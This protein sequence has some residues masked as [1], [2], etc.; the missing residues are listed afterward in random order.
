M[1]EAANERA[2][3]LKTAV[4]ELNALTFIAKRQL[5]LENA[6]DGNGV[7][8]AEWSAVHRHALKASL[9]FYSYCQQCVNAGADVPVFLEIADLAKLEKQFKDVDIGALTKQ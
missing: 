6:P 2:K 5:D 3:K 1:D 8:A 4:V 9:A 7:R